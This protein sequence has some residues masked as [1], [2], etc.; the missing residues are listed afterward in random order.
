MTWFLYMCFYIKKKKI[1]GIFNAGFE[2]LSILDIAKKIQNKIDCKIKVLKSNDPRS[3]RLDSSKI[4]KKGFKPLKGVE[5]A[6]LEGKDLFSK[7]KFKISNK[8][9][10]LKQMLKLNIK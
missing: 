6:I 7:K 3:Y 2:N 1:K 5:D 9:L 10:N 8:N 4:L